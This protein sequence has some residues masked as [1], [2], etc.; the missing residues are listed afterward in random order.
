[1]LL[2]LM[3]A[4][5]GLVDF[6]RRQGGV[7]SFY[8]QAPDE[9]VSARRLPEASLIARMPHQNRNLRLHTLTDVGII[10]V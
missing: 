6:T 7:F 3:R 2:S 5:H 1:M 9:F 10:A 8:E 4:D